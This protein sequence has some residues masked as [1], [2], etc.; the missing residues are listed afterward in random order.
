VIIHTCTPLR[1]GEGGR[2]EEELVFETASLPCDAW[3]ATLLEYDLDP[4]LRGFALPLQGFVYPLGSDK[5]VTDE[6]VWIRTGYRKDQTF[7]PGA[8][9]L[10]RKSV[11]TRFS[12]P[13]YGDYRVRFDFLGR[14]VA[15]AFLDVRRPPEPAATEAKQEAAPS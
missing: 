11:R 10:V 2:L 4:E 14:A 1:L 12:I 8:S 5:S 3:I 6:Q 15:N 7:Q 9:I 13:D